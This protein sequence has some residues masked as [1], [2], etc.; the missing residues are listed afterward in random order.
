M[1][2]FHAV[3]LVG[4]YRER[5]MKANRIKCRGYAEFHLNALEYDR[6]GF[7]DNP[8]LVVC[9]DNAS[10]TSKQWGHTY[11][12]LSSAAFGVPYAGV[13]VRRP[14]Q[15]GYWNLYYTKMPA[16]LLEPLFISDPKLA[17]V[18]MSDEGQQQ[19][20]E[21]FMRSVRTIFPEGGL[22]GLSVGH[23]GAR[24]GDRG[25]PARGEGGS[26]VGWEADIC[27]RV[28]SRILEAWP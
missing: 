21:I 25:A 13:H 9:A 19:M 15:R 1:A 12:E 26:V 4:G 27:D 2:E 10:A 18:A 23:L 5:Q 8:A 16:I 14:G 11:A 3:R 24:V 6:P 17:A 7:K 28:V 22:F 20:A